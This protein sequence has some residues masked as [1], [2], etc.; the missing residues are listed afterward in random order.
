MSE[1]ELSVVVG[2]PK[3]VLRT[4]S[5]CFHQN[6]YIFDF[7][8]QTSKSGLSLLVHVSIVILTDLNVSSFLVR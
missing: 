1:V 4:Q 6:I 8:E 7:R 5:T 3:T 2:L